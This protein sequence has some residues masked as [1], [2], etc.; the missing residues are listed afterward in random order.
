MLCRPGQVVAEEMM[1]EEEIQ[2][3]K[4][5][6]QN[7]KWKAP[8]AQARTA[9]AVRFRHFENF[10]FIFHFAFLRLSSLSFTPFAAPRPP[11]FRGELSS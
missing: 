2:N 3:E 10:H 7:E 8:L 11:C 1:S 6:V 4:C 5:K 9:F